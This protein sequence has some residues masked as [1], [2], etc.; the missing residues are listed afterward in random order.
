MRGRLFDK[1][2]KVALGGGIIALICVIAVFAPLIAPHD[3]Y[4]QS[5]VRRLKPPAF[6]LG[7]T[8][9]NPLGTDSY[10]RDLLSRLIYGSRT[11]MMVGVAAMALSCVLGTAAGLLAGYKGGRTEQAIMRC[12]DAHMAFP[13][14]LLAIIMTAALGGST[15]N[16]VLVLGISGWMIYAR[17]VF[18]LARSLKHRSFVEAAVSYGGSARYVMVRHLLPQVVPVLTV[19]ATLQIAQMILQE[20]ALSFLGLGLPPPA[21]TWG[22]ILSEGRERLF[23]APWIANAAGLAIILVVFGINILGNG[24]REYL[25]PRTQSR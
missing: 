6:M 17:L 10:G 23:G 13:D 5:L 9:A 11:S 20:A 4:Q 3:P 21:P 7:G 14:I 8:S 15:L 19:V 1:R 22:N 2:F 12:A 25:D 16:L 24:L 18:G